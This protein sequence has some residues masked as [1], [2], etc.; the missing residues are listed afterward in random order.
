MSN[1]F[2]NKHFLFAKIEPEI[3]TF[4]R[5]AKIRRRTAFYA[6][7]SVTALASGSTVILGLKKETGDGTWRIVALILSAL[8]AVIN[9]YIGF[10]KDAKLWVAYNN[11]ANSFKSLKLRIEKDTRSADL[12]EAAFEAYFAELQNIFDEVN[13][14]WTNERKNEKVNG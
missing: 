11:T 9:F 2:P 12:S 14:E 3:H 6:S 10:Q 7:L 8:I 5:K 1:L 13:K 4:E